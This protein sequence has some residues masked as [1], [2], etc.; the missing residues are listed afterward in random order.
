[1]ARH[2]R[3]QPA[4]AGQLSY[5]VT[6]EVAMTGENLALLNQGTFC[7]TLDTSAVYE[8]Y[9]TGTT[10]P[11]GA[12]TIAAMNGVWVLASSTRGA[13]GIPAYNPT[14]YAAANIYVDPANSTGLASDSNNGTSAITPLLTFDQ[15]IQRYGSFTPRLSITVTLHLLSSQPNGAPVVFSPILTGGSSYAILGSLTNVGAAFAAGAV[16]AKV[17]TATGNDLKV[18]GFTPGVHLPGMTVLNT[19]LGS[20]AIIDSITGGGVA[21]LTQPLANAGLTTVNASPTF[22]ED[23]GW[24]TGN[25]LQVCSQPQLD[26]Q[27]LAPSGGDGNVSFTV[28]CMWIQDVFIPDVSGTPGDGTMS[29]VPVGVGMTFSRCR[30]DMFLQYDAQG[31]GFGAYAA[32]CYLHGAA[33]M[34]QAQMVGGACN[35]G[36]V[37]T[38]LFED[39]AGID[40]DAIVHGPVTMKS[41]G[42][43]F[44]TAA[45]FDGAV[46]L[47]H[48]GTL[49]IEAGLAPVNVL[50]GT[51][52][53]TLN[54]EGPN[55]SV[56]NASG[57]TWVNCL[58]FP[59]GSLTIDANTTGSAYQLGTRTDG[60][61]ITPANL[62]TFNALENPYTGNRFSIIAT[63]ASP[64]GGL[65]VSGLTTAAM[66]GVTGQSGY[67]SGNSTASPTDNLAIAKSRFVGVTTGVTG[68]LQTTGVVAAVPMT[69]AGGSPAASAPLWLAASTDDGSTGAGKWTATA[70]VVAGTVVAEVGICIDNTNYAGAKTVKALIQVKP[71]VQL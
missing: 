56:Q 69:T 49:L 53:A 28:P 6:S 71:P 70:P 8:A 36:L 58:K 67:M 63:P 4:G 31:Q 21:T 42:Y 35:T 19:T 40:C 45:H 52:T 37:G 55:S 18:A 5:D 11:A 22:V 12:I 23:N 17:Q 54:L 46:S 1:M 10:P 51:G 7:V 26:L 65:I 9:P 30:F 15:V 32:G 24:T 29:A 20:S 50:W 2:V 13:P 25:T 41:G 44:G 16:T 68:Q 33:T 3:L 57:G 38:S 48:G 61:A 34:Q 39:V 47:A 60:Y 14:W 59:A 62:D 66:T 64:A 27:V 43:V